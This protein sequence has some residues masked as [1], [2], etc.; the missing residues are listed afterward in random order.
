MTVR[1]RLMPF[2]ELDLIDRRTRRFFEE[3][4]LAPAA[5]P[6]AD[7]FETEGEL[8]FEVE[9]PGFDQRE[10]EIEV[11]NHTLAVTGDRTERTEKLGRAMLLRE[12]LETHFERRFELPSEVERE[13]VKAEYAQGVLTVHVPKAAAHEKPFKIEI[14]KK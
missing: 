12:R 2:R 7:V 4:G 3:L 11:R 1:E 5:A 9:V 10:L 8:V 13:Q 6:A 14:A